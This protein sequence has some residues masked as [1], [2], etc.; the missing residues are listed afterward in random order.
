M[1]YYPSS[2]GGMP[3]NMDDTMKGIDLQMKQDNAK[4]NAHMQPEKA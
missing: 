2:S 3:E 4:K 1:K